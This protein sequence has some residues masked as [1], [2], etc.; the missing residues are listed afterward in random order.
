MGDVFAFPT[1]YREGVPRALLEAALAGLPIVTTDMPGCRDVISDRSTGLLV[2]PRDP[3]RLARAILELLDDRL[4]AQR[5]AVRARA[6]V[7][8]RFN[9]QLTVRRYAELYRELLAQPAPAQVHPAHASAS[10]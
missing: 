3:R 2:R 6:H 8:A 1:E 10:T 5:M 4:A 9:M 7:R